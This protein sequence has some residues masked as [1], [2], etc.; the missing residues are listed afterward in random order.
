MEEVMREE[1]DE[2]EDERFNKLVFFMEMRREG[3]VN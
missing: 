1:G 3:D 2:D